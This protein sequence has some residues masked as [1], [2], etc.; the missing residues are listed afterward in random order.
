MC[1]LGTAQDFEYSQMG[2]V[3]AATQ[4]EMARLLKVAM[5]SM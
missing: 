3:L 1:R 2:S 4:G 5:V